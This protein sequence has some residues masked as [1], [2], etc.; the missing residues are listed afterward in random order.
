MQGEPWAWVEWCIALVDV[1]QQLRHIHVYM[2]GCAVLIFQL[3]LGSNLVPVARFAGRLVGIEQCRSETLAT[4][5]VRSR[6]G[7]RT[8]FFRSPL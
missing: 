4:T 5:W 7:G 1:R 6:A 8:A 3:F 2:C